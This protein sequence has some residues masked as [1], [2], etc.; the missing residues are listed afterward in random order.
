MLRFAWIFLLIAFPALAEIQTVVP[1]D[2]NSI[3]A[4]GHTWS[5]NTI[6]D[7]WTGHAIVKDGRFTSEHGT[8]LTWDG[9]TLTLTWHHPYPFDPNTGLSWTPPSFTKN[10][11]G[12]EPTP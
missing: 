11:T 6:Q 12:A 5:F 1:G 9:T 2:G 3:N 10:L 7:D 8:K 4:F